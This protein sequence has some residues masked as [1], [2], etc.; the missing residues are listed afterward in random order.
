MTG[1][2]DHCYRTLAKYPIPLKS[3]AS[4][5]AV[6]QESCV[7]QPIITLKESPKIV[8]S[9]KIRMP[10]WTLTLMSGVCNVTK[11]QR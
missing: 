2:V 5:R 11:T 6:G 9:A 4:L 7:P 3:I 10:V 8:L 1:G